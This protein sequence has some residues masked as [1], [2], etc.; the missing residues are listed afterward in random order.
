LVYVVAGLLVV[1]GGVQEVMRQIEFGVKLYLLLHVAVAISNYSRY[2]DTTIYQ[3]TKVLLHRYLQYTN[4]DLYTIHIASIIIHQFLVS[5]DE[6]EFIISGP[7]ENHP[8]KI[9]AVVFSF[10]V[11]VITSPINYLIVKYERDKSNRTLINQLLSSLMI[12]VAI[13]G[14]MLQVKSKESKTS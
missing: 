5:S 9:F 14:T 2:P 3:G 12:F 4:I 13:P 1:V 11:M 6:D 7:Y 10:T 8:S